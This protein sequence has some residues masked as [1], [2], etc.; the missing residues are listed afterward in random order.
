M[1]PRPHHLTLRSPEVDEVLNNSPVKLVLDK[2]RSI[3]L[4]Y[5]FRPIEQVAV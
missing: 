5:V 3:A 4:M 2:H 1:V